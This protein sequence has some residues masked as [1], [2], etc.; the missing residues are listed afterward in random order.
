MGDSAP[1]SIFGVVLGK[2]SLRKTTWEDAKQIGKQA[3]PAVKTVQAARGVLKVG[4]EVVSEAH[5]VASDVRELTVKAS[6]VADSIERFMPSIQVMGQSFC[7]SAK[8]FS[9]FNI[10]TTTV[11]IGAELVLVY[12]GV[13]ALRLM[14]DTLKTISTS[15]AAQTAL[16]VQKEFSQYVYDMILERLDQTSDDPYF[17]HYFF[18]Y[19][20]DND[21]YPKFY[22]LIIEAPLG[23]R[24]GG[25]THQIDTVFMFMLATRNQINK[26]AREAQ[27][28][29]RPTLPIKLHLLIPAYQE[30]LITEPLRIPEEIG[31]FVMEGRVHGGKEFV[32]LNL[33]DDQQRY[34]QDIGLWHSPPP[35]WMKW[36]K[37][38]FEISLSKEPRVLGT[39]QQPQED[40]DEQGSE[41]GVSEV[42]DGSRYF[43]N[44]ATPMRHHTSGTR[45]SHPRSRRKHRHSSKSTRSI[46]YG[47][48]GRR[49]RSRSPP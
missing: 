1:F 47:G 44:Y 29:G 30:L 35:G 21:W 2:K 39:A 43:D 18:V 7:D 41:S 23:S 37:S 12:Q 16:K 48:Q 34:V 24:F 32:W 15:L 5:K 40:A 38:K 49:R 22:R 9:H 13:Q 17:I 10:I 14:N 27:K 11:K 4:G 45:N 6:K 3:L 26:E 19:H 8:I 31:D 36:A 28:R 20:P 46:S 25:Y 33:P 42:S